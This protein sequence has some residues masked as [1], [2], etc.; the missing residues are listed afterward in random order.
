MGKNRGRS[1]NKSDDPLI[2]EE[3]S[4]YGIFCTAISESMVLASDIF[5]S[6][7]EYM[8]AIG[9]DIALTANIEP[10]SF[11]KTWRY[12]R[13]IKDIE[14][15]CTWKELGGCDHTWGVSGPQVPEKFE[16]DLLPPN[17]KRKK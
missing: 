16:L 5:V 12:P 11:H 8:T 10:L 3:I 17:K 13:A 4:S 2:P 6:I 9:D 1:R 7:L 14:C 15:L